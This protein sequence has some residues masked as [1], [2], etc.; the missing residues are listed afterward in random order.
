MSLQLSVPSKTFVLGEYVALNGG[1]AIVLCTA[2]RFELYAEKKSSNA[3]YQNIHPQSPAGKLIAKNSFY[4]NY[5]LNFIDPYHGL[6]GLGASS[7]QFAMVYALQK[8]TQHLTD[9]EILA[10]L[11]LYQEYAW[12]GEGVPPSGAD[13]V[14]QLKGGL[15]FFHKER[16]IL[17][18]FSWPFE[19]CCFYL[20]HT[21]H[22][23]ATHEYLKNIGEEDYSELESV[24]FSG[25]ESIQKKN[26]HDF[27][28]AI[29][30][31]AAILGK[32][33]LVAEHTKKLLEKISL[34][35]GVLAAKGCGALGADIIFVLLNNQYESQ[36]EAWTKLQKLHVIS[37]GCKVSSGFLLSS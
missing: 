26:S 23:I 20:I 22:K 17:T 21:G 7:A 12:D 36:F 15:C 8:N 2:P 13:V 27:V 32:K 6:G 19:E 14:A 24:I 3:Q 35:T 31:Y 5:N 37:Q 10:A 18:N 29:Q 1:P 4:R 33:Q 16:K 9:D 28:R 30:L 25:L 34:Q 11:D